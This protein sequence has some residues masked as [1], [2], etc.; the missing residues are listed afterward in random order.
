MFPPLH[1]PGLG[2]FQDGALRHN[3]PVNIALWESDRIWPRET[4][5]DV[6]LSLGTGTGPSATTPRTATSTPQLA[7]SEKFIPR[8]FRSF[9]TGLDGE[10]TWHELLHHLEKD[11]HDRYFRL[12]INMASQ[13][14]RLDDVRA[15][16]SLSNAVESH[17]DDP[18][19][20]DIKMALLAS[21][22][23]FELKRTPTFDASGFYVCQGE[24]R[25]RMDHTKVFMAL[26][27][28]G[29]SPI[30]FFKD[31]VSLRPSDP[32]T[33][34]CPGCYRFR[35]KV[36]FF[37]RHPSE[38]ISITVSMGDYQ[39][40]LSGFPKTMTWFAATQ[41]LTSPFYRTQNVALPESLYDCFKTSKVTS[42]ASVSQNSSK[43]TRWSG[44]EN[45]IKRRM[46]RFLSLPNLA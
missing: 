30:E 2:R 1:I 27:Q 39:R 40:S 28:M 5:K 9:L 32:S 8:L 41:N 4:T 10:V 37:I 42:T 12:N 24:I 20:I 45:H 14:P 46:P 7:F 6:V 38:T 17:K 11:V 34:V 23:F 25:T 16:Q 15:I 22:F 36:C 31:H 3:N 35:K 21:C 44:T 19:I 43:R 33:D 13:E 29:T 18:K 26:R